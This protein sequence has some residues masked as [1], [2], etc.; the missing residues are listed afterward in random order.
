MENGIAEKQGQF[1]FAISS[2]SWA[3]DQIELSFVPES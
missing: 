1:S 2:L 3:K